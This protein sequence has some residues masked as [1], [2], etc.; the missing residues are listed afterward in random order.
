MNTGLFIFICIVTFL[1][2][3]AIL[4][5]APKFFPTIL[6]GRTKGNTILSLILT[7]VFIAFYFI[8]K[9]TTEGFFFELT[10]EK[11]CDGGPYMYSSDPQK[12]ALCSKFSKGDLARYEC[13]YGNPDLTGR[14]LYHG[15]P[16]WWEGAGNGTLSNAK[17]ENPSCG[18]I[19]P[20]QKDPQVL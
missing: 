11:K 3:L 4:S 10:P 2:L 20:D 15:R 19:N 9:S 1:L 14:M 7:L 13:S 5:F 12:Q 8:C 16:V 18:D 17:W 6:D